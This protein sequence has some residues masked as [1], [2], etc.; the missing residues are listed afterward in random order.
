LRDGQTEGYLSNKQDEQDF[1][2]AVSHLSWEIL[3]YFEQSFNDRR[4]KL[5]A[6][7][8]FPASR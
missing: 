8:S 3:T 4:V 5:N 2:K 6:A 1:A 7:A